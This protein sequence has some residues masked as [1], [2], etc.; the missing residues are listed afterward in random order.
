MPTYICHGFRWPRPLIRIHII[1]QNLDDAAAEWLMAPRTTETM[2]QNF[3]TIYPEIMPSLP[4]L[5]FVEQYDPLDES[6]ESKSQPYAYVCDVVHEVKLGIE[7]DE[8]RGK[9]VPNDAWTAMMDLRDK[10]AP[11]EKVSW[12]VVVCGDVE[13]WSPP[14]A[15]TLTGTVNGLNGLH[16]NGRVNGYKASGTNRSSWGRD[17][18]ETSRP[19][20]S[21]SFKKL[22]GG[23]VLRKSKSMKSISNMSG[24]QPNSPNEVPP[25][26]QSPPLSSLPAQQAQST[27][28]LAP[29]KSGPNITHAYARLPPE[30]RNPPPPQRSPPQ[31]P[32]ASVS[33]G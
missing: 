8:V 5:K 1:L 16:S 3:K 21:R 24:S 30:L 23:G 25:L 17:D 27:A 10:L 11:G 20:T 33:G 31:A 19:S 9:G 26:P 13:R 4:N 18:S 32:E 6:A 14:E 15:N 2:L 29:P 28:P 7:F 12:F 22:F